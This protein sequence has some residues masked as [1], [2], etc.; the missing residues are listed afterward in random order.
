MRMMA[1]AKKQCPYK[2]P[3]NKKFSY[4]AATHCLADCKKQHGADASGS[5]S[6]EKG[7]CNCVANC[8]G[9]R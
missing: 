9:S 2:I 6:A 3:I 8:K 1:D 7:F 4:C 5:C